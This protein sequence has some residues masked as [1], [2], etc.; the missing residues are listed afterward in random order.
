MDQKPSKATVPEAMVVAE[1]AAAERVEEE[2]AVRR[3]NGRPSGVVPPPPPPLSSK[4]VALAAV[5]CGVAPS[6][7]ALWTVACGVAVAS[8]GVRVGHL[9]VATWR[10]LRPASARPRMLDD[11]DAPP[12]SEPSSS[13]PAGWC[14]TA[15][16]VIRPGERQP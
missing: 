9:H 5:A 8:L 10:T 11:P 6:P 14:G 16:A 7:P 13:S 2:A 15:R 3:R 12:P 4:D 1:A